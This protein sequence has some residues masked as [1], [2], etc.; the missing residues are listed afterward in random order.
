MKEYMETV[1]RRINKSKKALKEA[2]IVLMKEKEFKKITITE[3]V[4]FADLNRGTFYKHYQYKEDLLDEVIEDVFADLKDSYRAP[5]HNNAMF[6]EERLSTSAIKI[7]DHVY[8]FSN[9]Y[10]IIIKAN[11]LPGFPSRICEVLKELAINDGLLDQLDSS[12]DKEIYASYH[13]YSL[14]GMIV[15]WVNGGFKYTSHHM[16]EQL[17][18]IISTTNRSSYKMTDLESSAKERK[19]LID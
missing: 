17:L 7:F 4:D 15:E 18:Q 13:A 19:S 11:G 16:A 10:T 14:L 1:D 5:Y 9:F 3:I 8:K 6:F 2:L 12:I